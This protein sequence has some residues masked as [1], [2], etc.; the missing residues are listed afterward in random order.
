MQN[1]C[2]HKLALDSNPG[3]RTYSRV[4]CGSDSNAP[5]INDNLPVMKLPIEINMG[6]VQ[7][8]RGTCCTVSSS[9]TNFVDDKSVH[10]KSCGL[11]SIISASIRRTWADVQSYM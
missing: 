3:R 10:L 5:C 8:H 7:G 9:N 2:V 1:V 11:E 6:L 4:V